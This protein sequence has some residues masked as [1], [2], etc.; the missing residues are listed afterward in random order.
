MTASPGLTPPTYTLDDLRADCEAGT[1]DTI[2]IAFT[3]MQGRLAGKRLHPG[4]FFGH[5]LEHGTEGCNYLLTADVEMNTIEGYALTSWERGYGDFAFDLDLSTLRRTPGEPNSATIL[6]DLTWVSGPDAGTPV[7][8]SPR[9]VLTAQVERA[10]SLGYEAF[11]GTEL[12]FILFDDTYEQ[13]WDARYQGLTGSNRYNVDYSILG[14]AKVEP[15]L[16]EIRNEMWRSGVTVESAKGECNLGQHEIV[17]LY[18][19]VLRA[20]DT[21]SVYKTAAKLIADAHGKA[22][23]FMAKYDEREGNSCHVHLSL[24]SADGDVVFAASDGS[25]DATGPESEY[26]GHS[27]LFDH[28][29]AGLQSTLAEFTLFYAPNINSY[30]RF[31]EGSFAPTAVAWGRDNRSCALRV[32][33]HGA[34]LRVENRLPGGDVNPYLAVAA[35]L[36]GGLHGIAERLPLEPPCEGNA[37]AAGKARVPRTLREARDLFDASAL[38]RAAFGD[39]VVDHYVHAAD[40]EL[41]A[42]EAA[43]T[44]WERVRG[45]ERL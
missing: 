7:R 23:T 40:V 17:F 10:A 43:V 39:D 22:L 21:H 44:D 14:G 19:R 29:L 15:V 9:S 32:V 11:A 42:F 20:C 33:G 34:G 31:A 36:A 2:V 24:R 5:V 41:T 37:Y 45:F 6:A 26:E 4:F 25:A 8:P 16:R 3:D 30:K 12:E 18:D 27:A 35:M 13:A 1:V 28:F 38:A